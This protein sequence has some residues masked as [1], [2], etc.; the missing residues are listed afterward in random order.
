MTKILKNQQGISILL[1]ILILSSLMVL[2]VALSAIVLR[3]GRSTRQIGQSEVAFYAAETAIEK[4]LYEIEKNHSVENLDVATPQTMTTSDGQWTRS[5]SVNRLLDVDCDQLSGEG[6]CVDVVGEITA[7]NPLVVKL[8]PGNSFQ[9][10]MNFV[11]MNLPNNVQIQEVEKDGIGK[12]IALSSDGIQTSSS[13]SPVNLH[14]L[15]DKLYLLRLVNED[16]QMITF[17]VK[18]AQGNLPL[19]IILTG[20]GIYQQETRIIEIERKTW[21]IY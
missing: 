16:T 7:S 2:T 20:T 4:G 5:Y 3:V 9:I 11:G 8:S 6:I 13:D 14:D 12:V 19:G 18:P 1:V 10:D 17:R 15:E 21:Q